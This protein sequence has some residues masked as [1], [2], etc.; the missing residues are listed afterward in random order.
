[1]AAPPAADGAAMARQEKRCSRCGR[2]R[3]ASEFCRN[4]RSADG[5][6]SQCRTCVSAKVCLHTFP[7]LLCHDPAKSTLSM[8]SEFAS[9][10][11]RLHAC[12]VYS[13]LACSGVSKPM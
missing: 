13:C 10:R 8:Q 7:S 12:R 2:D 3:P 5:L 4:K 9:L 6:Y 11:W 1:M